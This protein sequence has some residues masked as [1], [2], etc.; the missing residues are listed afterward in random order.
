MLRASLVVLLLSLACLVV[1]PS[2]KAQR[3]GAGRSSG[4][5]IDVQVRYATG[6]PGP[7]GIHVRLESAEGGAAGDCQTRDGGK[8]QFNL[9]SSGVYI[10]RVAEQGYQEVSARVELI[11]SPRGYAT[12]ELKPIPEKTPTEQ[13]KTE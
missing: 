3:P 13:P 5:V 10:L 9:D 2:L 7:R 4:G 8:C 6:E 12:L 1:A 11:G